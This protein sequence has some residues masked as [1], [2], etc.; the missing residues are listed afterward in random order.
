V[1]A[2]GLLAVVG[3]SAARRLV[4]LPEDELVLRIRRLTRLF[5][6]V[7]LSAALDRSIAS[8][9]RDAMR[10]GCGWEMQRGREQLE[11]SEAVN[12]RGKA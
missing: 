7:S 1:R 12:L 10:S 5:Q 11:I 6:Q 2:G 8:P 4:F 9:G 3:L